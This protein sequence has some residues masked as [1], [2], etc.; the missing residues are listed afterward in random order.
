M[1]GNMI[2]Y[3]NFTVDELRSYEELLRKVQLPISDFEDMADFPPMCLSVNKEKRNSFMEKAWELWS[4]GNKLLQTQ[5]PDNF[6]PYAALEKEYS[7]E[8]KEAKK[9][10]KD[11][12]GN[13]MVAIDMY[14]KD[15]PSVE[16]EDSDRH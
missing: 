15:N 14:I 9:Y 11:S 1:D 8:I 13:R 5:I 16:I 4:A 7:K 6:R 3:E 2:N 12:N 10:I